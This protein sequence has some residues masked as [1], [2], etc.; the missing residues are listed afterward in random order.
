[1][2]GK[3]EITGVYGPITY[4]F[5]TQVEIS[6]FTVETQK[7]SQENKLWIA[8]TREFEDA[9]AIAKR[10]ESSIQTG[11]RSII[12]YNPLEQAPF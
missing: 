9:E 6:K 11:G 12:V 5:I 8:D 2:G 10:R 1:M 3:S 7:Q 4:I